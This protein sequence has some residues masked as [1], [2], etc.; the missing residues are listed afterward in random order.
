[1]ASAVP[2]E[3]VAA[4]SEHDRR[5]ALTERGQQRRDAGCENFGFRLTETREPGAVGEVVQMRGLDADKV[6]H[7]GERVEHLGLYAQQA[8]V[9]LLV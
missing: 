4:S 5:Y 1:M 9:M 3:H 8:L 6:Q 7:A 2:C